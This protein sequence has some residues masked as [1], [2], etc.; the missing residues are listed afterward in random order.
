M[1]RKLRQKYFVT[2]E[3]RLSIAIIILWSLLITAFFTYFAKELSERIG[4]G[5][6]LF[7]IIMAGYILIVIVLTMLFSHRLIG[8][9]QR[10]KTEIKLITSGDCHRRLKIRNNDDIYIRSFILEVNRLLDDFEKMHRCTE[11]L[12]R[13][14]DSELLNILSYIEEGEPSKEKLRETVLAFHKKLKALAGEARH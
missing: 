3:L 9:F 5:T 10:L 1:A 6:L 14:I 4:D 8:P 12:I 11:S 7:V 2:K 13:H